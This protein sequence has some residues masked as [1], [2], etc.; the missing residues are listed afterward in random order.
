MVELIKSVRKRELRREARIAMR[1]IN[2]VHTGDI[3]AVEKRL[4]RLYESDV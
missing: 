1:I 3:G 2:S 4:Q